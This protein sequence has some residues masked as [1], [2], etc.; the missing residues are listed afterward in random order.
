M[1]SS[2]V[3]PDHAFVVF[4]IWIVLSAIFFSFILF[5]NGHRYLNEFPHLSMLSLTLRNAYPLRD[6]TIQTVPF[7]QIIPK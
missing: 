1:Y 3:L 7:L 5:W 2:S 6:F 4:L